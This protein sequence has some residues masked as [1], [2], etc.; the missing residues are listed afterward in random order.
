ML[1]SVAIVEAAANPEAHPVFEPVRF[2]EKDMPIL[3][4]AIAAEATHLITGDLHFGPHYCQRI[5][6]VL[7]LP[8]ARYLREFA[9]SGD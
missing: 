6:G 3:L 9:S 5:V 7:V 1:A 4:A 8:P 2:P